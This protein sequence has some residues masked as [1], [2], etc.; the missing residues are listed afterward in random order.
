MKTVHLNRLIK[1]IAK[2]DTVFYLLPPLMLLLVAGTLAQRWLGLY[3]AQH[4]FFSSFILWAGPLPL[5]G[6]YTLTGILAFS[7]L[8]KFVFASDWNWKRAGIILTHLGVLVLLIGGLLT[9]L[10]AREG[11]IVLPEGSASPY[12]Y[13]YHSREL[14]IFKDEDLQGRTDFSDLKDKLKVELPFTISVLQSCENCR[15]VEAPDKKGRRGMAQFMMLEPIP[16]MIE[17]EEN[18]S[19][20]MLQISGANKKDNGIYIV[21]EGMP[22]PIEITQGKSV[23]K[24]IFGK[25][26]RLLPFSIALIDFVKTSYPGTDTAMAYHSDVI[27]QDGD[28]EWPVRIEMNKP[29]RYK[30]YTFYQSSFEQTENM[31]ASILSVV[32]NKGQVFPYLGAGIIAVGLMLHVM[33][34]AR[35]GRVT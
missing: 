15:I 30:G 29:L 1:K 3:E 18:F 25:Q 7:L 21:F 17:P 26:Q 28:L 11:F 34:T 33:I 32:E 35:K 8:L 12:I 10:S 4:Q 23:Y 9:A 19:G 27:V 31:Q 20:A 14:F 2:A 16:E 13:D 22:Q 5:P 6:G 24:I